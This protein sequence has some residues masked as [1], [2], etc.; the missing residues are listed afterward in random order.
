VRVDSDADLAARFAGHFPHVQLNLPVWDRIRRG[1]RRL[2]PGLPLVVL[3]LPVLPV[4][5][6]MAMVLLAERALAPTGPRRPFPLGAGRRSFP[7]GRQ[8]PRP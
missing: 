2:F 3:V 5:R 4:P 8:T 1:A 7:S 6:L